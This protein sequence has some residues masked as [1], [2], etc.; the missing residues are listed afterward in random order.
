MEDYK[1][2]HIQ[3]IKACKKGDRKAQTKLYSLYAKAMFNTAYRIL[4][5]V[6]EAEDAM[7]DAFIKA[8]NK[9]AT[10]SEAVSFGAWLKKIVIN[11]SLD[12]LRKQKE[13]FENIEHHEHLQ[14]D[15]QEVDEREI[16]FEALK[17]RNAILQLP[18]GYRVI[19]SLYLLE[20]YDHEEISEILSIKAS[21]SRSQLVRAKKKL[22]NIIQKDKNFSEH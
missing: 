4:N 16:A 8:F 5:D 17:V 22:L 3:L 11:T 6:H 19:L 9:L 2:I 21:T 1:N 15:E 14:D 18:A 12:V 7:Q 10:Y 20:G 13:I